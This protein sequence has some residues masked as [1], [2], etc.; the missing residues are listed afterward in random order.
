MNILKNVRLRAAAKSLA[1]VEIDESVWKPDFDIVDRY[2]C[3]GDELI[4]FGLLSFAG[5]GFLIQEILP[6]GKPLPETCTTLMLIASLLIVGCVILALFHRFNSTECLYCQIL[7]M[8]SLK[9]L[10]NKHWSEIEIKQEK[11]FIEVTRVNQRK[12]SF[13]AHCCLVGSA[14]SFA[15]GLLFTLFVF[16]NVLVRG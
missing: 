1:D 10:E 13:S 4:K 9:R 14:I 11:I 12:V 2:Q 7:I 5:F 8:R 3:L 6:K 15:I 16:H